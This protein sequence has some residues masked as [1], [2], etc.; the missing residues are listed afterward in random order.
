M[1]TSYSIP[2]LCAA[3]EVSSSGYYASRQQI[4]RPR[5][6]ANAVLLCEIKVIHAHRH[7]RAYGSPRMT[8]ELRDRK[9]SCSRNRVA[10][11]MRTA[12]LRA[13]PR[14]PFRPKTTHPDHAAHPSLNLLKDA[15]PPTAPGQ[16]VVTDITYLPTKEGWLYLSVIIDLFSRCVLGWKTSTSLHADL[17][18]HTIQ[19]ASSAILPHSIF[20]SD[21]GC[22]Y[23]SQ[24]VRQ[25]LA[26]HR[27]KQSMSARGYCYDNAFA[28]SFFASLKAEMLPQNGVFDSIAQANLA[29]FDY[30]ETFYNKS[31]RHSSLGQISPL[32]FL[33]LYFQNL[34][35]NLN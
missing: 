5:A 14:R 33:N 35:P 31:R 22:Q 29:L 24:R 15:T 23:S 19:Q 11:L 13:R 32:T 3:F 6:E 34:Q 17:V 26:S 28:E 9:L 21:R 18:V 12:G 1:R 25:C 20:H 16:Q 30:L 10:R 8:S 27:W 4:S 2:E 7:T